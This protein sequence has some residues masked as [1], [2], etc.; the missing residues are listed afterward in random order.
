MAETRRRGPHGPGGHGAPRGGYQKPKNMGK[1]IGTLLGYVGKSRW[2]LAVV[3]V[4]LVLNTVCS[5]GG[6]YLLR[7][8]IDECIVPGDYARLARMLVL[9]ACVYLCAA[10]FSYTYS[11][12]MVHVSQ[13]TTHAIRQDLFARM[14][15][16]P[17]SYFDTHTHGELMS[18]Y[19]N[20]I[21]TITE[22]L[23]NGLVSLCSGVLT[24]V[25]VVAV[26]L[27]LSPLLFLVTVFSLWLMLLVIM[28]V[29]KRS[30][31]YFMAQQ[32]DLGI[33]NG[34]IEEMVE[35]QKVIKVFNH[36]QAAK[37]GFAQ[38]NEA[39]RQSATNAQSFAG[40]MMPAMGNISHINYALTCCVGALLSIAI[41]LDLGALLV[42]LQYTRQVSQPIGQMSQQVNNLLAA[43]A[44]A[45]R[46]FEVMET[47]PEVDE[48]KV[49]LV[50]TSRAADG[51]ITEAAGR[52]DGW[53]WK[54]PDGSLVPLRGDVRFQ[55]VQFGYVPGKAILHGISLY[56][57]PG[58][59][60]AFVGSTG[61]GKTTITNLI[62]RFYEIDSGLITYDGIDV[63]EI[64][65][66]SL[67]R[68]LGI[69]LQ[70]THL[71]TGTIADNIRYGKLDAT[72]EEVRSAARLANADTFIRHLPDGYDTWITDD[73]GSL[74]QGERQLLAIA[75][76]AVADPPVLILD[77]ATSSI[78][79]RTEKLIER[80]MDQLMAD[81]TVFVIAHRLS[82]VRNAKAIMVLE[83]GEIIERGDHDDLLSQG[84]KYY[85]LYTGQAELS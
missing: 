84:G 28:T 71:F 35:G 81:R 57:K 7:P 68:S 42:Y 6:S 38:R 1:T 43:I 4:C 58:Q 63:R 14:Q 17:L 48:G 27:Y 62:N 66:E 34:Y 69:V 47:T 46:V 53:A 51:S 76:A 85:Q 25:G 72:D 45:E 23:N 77:E 70:D 13:K 67:R 2:L 19:T 16:L 24:F 22:I 65:K 82:T 83:Q 9:M 60:I 12:I 56:A 40:A 15:G 79:T 41:G 50:H 74:S 21:E 52:S 61:A 32:R 8:L 20:D 30:R 37:E 55:D 5:V 73:G 75:R 33:I 36:E 54:R 44:G 3:A 49:T 26:M 29:G 31:R 10:L 80:G 39:Y 18:R 64:S 11:R 59:K 78:D